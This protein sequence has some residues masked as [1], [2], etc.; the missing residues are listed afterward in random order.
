MVLF[1]I[2]TVPMDDEEL[3]PLMR[4]LVKEDGRFNGVGMRSTNP[5]TIAAKLELPETEIKSIKIRS[6]TPD[7]GKII[8]IGVMVDVYQSYADGNPVHT[9]PEVIVLQGMDE[10]KILNDFLDLIRD[11]GTQIITFN[12]INF[13]VPFIIKRCLYKQIHVNYELSTRRFSIKPHFDLLQ[14]LS[15]YKTPTQGLKM[16]EYCSLFG[17]DTTKDKFSGADV[18]PAY[19]A[20][21]WDRLKQYSTDDCNFTYDLFMAVRPYC[22][23]LFQYDDHK[24]ANSFV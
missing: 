10:R 9:R 15:N 19:I 18:Y 3:S 1:D 22:G 23:Y 11:Y 2:E 24:P 7:L 20:G 4:K 6:L 13:D 8:S 17:I 12:G 21:E 14:Y 16:S 5:D